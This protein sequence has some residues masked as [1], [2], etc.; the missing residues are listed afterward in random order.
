MSA[1]SQRTGRKTTVGTGRVVAPLRSTGSNHDGAGS[2]ICE[3]G[4]NPADVIKPPKRRT[5]EVREAGDREIM[6][7][8]L[9]IG[10]AL[11]GSLGAAHAQSEY[12]AGALRQRCR[13]RSS[14]DK[15]N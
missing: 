5:E 1:T 11:L 4:T 7:L 3:R 14:R 15:N 9:L 2:R 10:L 8:K 13:W 6:N 12:D